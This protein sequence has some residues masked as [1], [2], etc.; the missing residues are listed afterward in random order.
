MILVQPLQ[1]GLQTCL[2]LLLAAAQSGILPAQSQKY[3]GKLALTIQF[4]PKQQP[5][6]PSELFDILPLKIN[7]PLR[8]AD[9]R[10]SIDRLFA[11]GKYADIQVDAEPYNDGVII[12]F[13]TKNSWFIGDVSF[14][15]RIWEP[16]S[17]G[18]L[19]NA[20]RLELGQPYTEA[21]LE[22]AIAFQQRLL[23]GNGLY[24]SN[25]HPVF[26]W[27]SVHQQANIRFEIAGGPRAHFAAPRLT[28]DLKMDPG[29]ILTATKFRRWMVHTW[30]PV[31]QTRVRQGIEGVRSLYQ[32]ENRLEAKVSLDSV[33]YD[34]QTN[35]AIP[36]L[37]IDA[38]PRIDRKSVV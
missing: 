19:E 34:P 15:G 32:Q 24:G 4:D 22:Q 36:T 6:A 29:K 12:R 7:Q 1:S 20:T 26:D 31:T 17:A 23:E 35:S 3:E 10:A 16:P 18:Q 5:L 14:A 28:G 11:T 2:I 37:R 27:D 25:I 13:I 9:V 8:M 21:K 30:K 33:E 38:G